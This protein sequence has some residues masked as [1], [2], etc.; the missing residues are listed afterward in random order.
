MYGHVMEKIAAFQLRC[1]EEELAAWKK[2]AAMKNTSLSEYVRGL[3]NAMVA[4]DG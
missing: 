4:R 1:T 3:L 2:L